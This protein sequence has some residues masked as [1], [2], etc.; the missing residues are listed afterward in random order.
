MS[1]AIDGLGSWLG[2]IYLL[3]TFLLVLAAFFVA[4]LKQPA[5]RMSA[6]RATLAGLAL[7]AVLSALPRWPRLAWRSPVR[8][9]ASSGASVPPE[10]KTR[11]AS[12]L[13]V[14]ILREFEI[15]RGS[16]PTQEPQ[17][18]LSAVVLRPEAATK[19]ACGLVDST[20]E[21]AGT[22]WLPPRIRDLPGL[23]DA[24]RDPGR[25]ITARITAAVGSAR[26]HPVATCSGE[27]QGTTSAGQHADRSASCDRRPQSLDRVS[28]QVRRMRARGTARGSTGSRTGSHPPW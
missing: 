24:G 22:L 6:A 25:A 3:S 19:R 21:F 10:V 28:G 16:R 4:F 2:D 15:Q 23:V 9:E 27:R 17:V 8:S 1:Q 18:A 12:G 26:G 7:V 14:P 5:R 20:L 11:G 13:A